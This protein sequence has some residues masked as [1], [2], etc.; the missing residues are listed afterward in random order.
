MFLQ[1][2]L[3]FVSTFVEL[4]QIQVPHPVTPSPPLLMP[5]S[6]S[7]FSPFCFAPRCTPIALPIKEEVNAAIATAL[8]PPTRRNPIPINET[9]RVTTTQAAKIGPT[10]IIALLPNRHPANALNLTHPI[11]NNPLTNINPPTPMTSLPKSQPTSPL[12]T[13]PPGPLNQ[14]SR[15][16]IP[17]RK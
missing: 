14:L 7:S 15:R 9:H 11:G 5:V 8:T 4:V 17:K 13:S 6:H 12:S 10:H 3:P 2:L 16:P 1:H